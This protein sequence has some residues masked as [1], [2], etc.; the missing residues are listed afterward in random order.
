[1][2]KLV[3]CHIITYNQKDFVRQ[4]IDG[5]LMQETTFDYELVIGDDF[6]TDGTR[7]LI[8]EYANNY[9]NKIQLN[10]R[11]KRGKGVPGKENFLTTLA[12]CKNKYVSLCDGDDYWTDPHKLQKQVDFLEANP[13]YAI[14]AHN[15]QILSQNGTVK[16]EIKKSVIENATIGDLANGMSIYTPSCVF[17]NGLFGELPSWFIDCPVGDYALHMLNAQYGKIKILPDIMA[18]Y[19]LH[20][21]SSWEAKDEVWRYVNWIKVLDVLIGKFDK[22]INRILCERQLYVINEMNQ[23]HIDKVDALVKV[24]YIP[25]CFYFLEKQYLQLQVDNKEM[26]RKLY[27]IEN[28]RIYKFINKPITYLLTVLK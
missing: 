21:S 5:V 23:K 14:C 7:E 6:S 11:N 13:D 20:S 3:S 26:K 8:L 27:L 2:E 10:L 19:R 18:V 22:K 16:S 4:C 28:S 17:R 1:M 25:K 15:V 24:D 9:P 12:L